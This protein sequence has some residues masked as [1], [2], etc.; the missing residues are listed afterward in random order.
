MIDSRSFLDWVQASPPRA[1]FGPVQ[2]AGDP[3]RR[4][5]AERSALGVPP[6]QVQREAGLD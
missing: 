1:G 3:E 5:R 4:M 6:A 2:V